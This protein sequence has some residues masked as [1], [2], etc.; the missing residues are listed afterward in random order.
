MTYGLLSSNILLVLSNVIRAMAMIARLEPERALIRSY[1]LRITRSFPISRHATST[2]VPLNWFL[3]IAVI[4]PI[5]TLSALEYCD[6]VRP[7]YAASWSALLNR[8]TSWSSSSN[9]IAAI[10]PI[11]GTVLRIFVRPL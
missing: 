5:R 10:S 3:P 8:S 6:G 7:T 4:R 11:P 9:S 1:F 2:N